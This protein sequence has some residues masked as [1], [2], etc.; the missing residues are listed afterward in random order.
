M[1]IVSSSWVVKQKLFLSEKQCFTSCITVFS[2]KGLS[3]DVR[4]ISRILDI[5]MY[6]VL[7]LLLLLLIIQ[8]N[9]SGRTG[10]T[11]KKKKKKTA[12]QLVDRIGLP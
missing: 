10:T 2:P 6:V 5:I 4:E 7:L 1:I 8:C 9:S 12:L 11:E 3:C